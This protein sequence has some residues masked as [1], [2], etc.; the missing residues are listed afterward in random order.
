MLSTSATAYSNNPANVIYNYLASDDGLGASTSEIDLASF[1]QA[2]A[3]A[4]TVFRLQVEHKIDILVM[5]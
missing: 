5:V 4:T 2:R 3:V 1:Q